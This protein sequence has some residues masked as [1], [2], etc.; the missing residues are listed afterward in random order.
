MNQ[1]YI[2]EEIKFKSFENIQDEE[3]NIVEDDN[4]ERHS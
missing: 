2:F 1:R 4:I 3:I